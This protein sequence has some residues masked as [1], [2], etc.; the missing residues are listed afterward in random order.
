MGEQAGNDGPGGFPEGFGDPKD[1]D[2]GQQQNQQ[3]Q[4]GQQG[5][6]EGDDDGDDQSVESLPKWAQDKLKA[7]ETD[8]YKYRRDARQARGAR[9]TGTQQAQQG[10]QNQQGQQGQQGQPD[11]T[12]QIEEARRQARADAKAEYSERLAGTRIES[13][14]AQMGIANP[15]QV[16]DDLNLARYVT[17]DGEVDGEMVKGVIERYRSIAPKRRRTVGAAGSGGAGS[18]GTNADK[19][20]E[21]VGLG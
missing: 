21:A 6:D 16:V 17:D 19:F 18:A 10:Q 3:G 14:L 4:Q 9:Q 11:A 13:A 5:A 12:Q 8:N 7:L 2:A 20:A 15:E 1:G